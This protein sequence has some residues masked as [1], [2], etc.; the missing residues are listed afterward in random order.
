M[1]QRMV[2]ITGSG[3]DARRKNQC[4]HWR[5][6]DERSVVST[7]FSGALR[8]QIITGPLFAFSAIR[9]PR[10]AFCNPHSAIRN[11]HS[12]I[13][14]PHS[15]LPSQIPLSIQPQS[16]PHFHLFTFLSSLRL[17]LLEA[18]SSMLLETLDEPRSLFPL[19]PPFFRFV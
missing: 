6:L 2:I 1:R 10:S 16:Q 19:S 14:Y 15:A 12:A 4:Y 7:V 13:H 9:I 11:P 17:L 18:D 5:W 3:F 8:S